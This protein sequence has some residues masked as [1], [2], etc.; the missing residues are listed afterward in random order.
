LSVFLPPIGI[1][2]LAALDIVYSRENM[3][4]LARS[5]VENFTEIMVARLE[6]GGKLIDRAG[7]DNDEIG[8]LGP[9]EYLRLGRLP[10]LLLVLDS[11][12]D[13][14]YG[15]TNLQELVEE[16]GGDLPIGIALSMQDSNGERF[17]IC[18]YPAFF[19]KYI[20]VG[21]I[22]WRDLPEA[23]MRSGYLWSILIGAM[24]LWGAISIWR[25][26]KL[27]VR[28]LGSLESEIS[29]LKWGEELPSEG[30]QE[31]F[32][33]LDRLRSTFTR[34]A[35][36]A[37]N[38]VSV[39][40]TCMNDMV[41]V[42]EAERT[43]ISRDIH[44]GP[45]QDV[46]ALI[47]RIHLAKLPD[48]TPE[49]TKRELDLAEKIAMTTVREMR[50]L[51]DFLNPPWLELGLQQALTELTERQSSQYGVRIFLDVDEDIEFS[52]SV[53]L[54]FFRVVQEA[55][56][57]SVRHG[58]AKN[59]WV[60]VKKDEKGFELVVQDDGHGFDMHESGT[61]GLRVEG[62]RGL[63]NM[64]ERMAIV[65]GRLKIISYPGEGTCIRGLIP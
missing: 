32:Y 63:S 34:V 42:A 43:K 9:H 6:N 22:S 28:P 12:G 25:L 31:I 65:G 52:E 35:Q 16:K 10:G 51:C 17:T 53:T 1:I 62:H 59:I 60:D 54:S 49:D 19:G 11:E 5:Y 4:I 29:S 7:I 23:T 14:L 27:V 3:E 30:G 58:E 21:A 40:K 24:G 64:E 56:T 45:L 48:N 8:V 50:G 33:E 26:W 46:T 57:N 13:F 38:R 2:L 55:V 18:A 20:V 44:D 15:S 41:T 47:Q 36:D 39:I 37:I 61:A